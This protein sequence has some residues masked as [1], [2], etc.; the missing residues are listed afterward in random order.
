MAALLDDL[1]VPHLQIRCGA[2]SRVRIAVV[3]G[4]DDVQQAALGG[5]LEADLTGDLRQGWPSSGT[6]RASN[7]S[8]PLGEDPGD[9]A[10]GHAAGMEGTHGQLGT[11]LTGDGSV[12]RWM[13]LASPGPTWLEVA[14]F[15]L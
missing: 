9:V 12:R 11:G 10:A 8:L 13:R 1:A 7:S 6:L 2:W 3:G 14:K 5:I 15:I 4:D